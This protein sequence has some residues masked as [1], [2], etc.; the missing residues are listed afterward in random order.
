MSWR[1]FGS[2]SIR[3]IRPSSPDETRCCIVGGGPA[4]MV[5]AL[6]L[7]RAGVPVTLLEAHADFDRDFRGD[8]IHPYTLELME[9]LGLVDDLLKIPH[10][11]MERV[12][13]QTARGVIKAA[14]FRSLGGKYPYQ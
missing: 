5:L 10:R 9:R 11:R 8:S 1:L 14:D 6:L 3:V 13:F 4:G 7:A 2:R 12:E